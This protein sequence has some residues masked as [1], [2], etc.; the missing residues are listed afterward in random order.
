MQLALPQRTRRQNK[1]KGLES[2]IYSV[3]HLFSFDIPTYL[4]H[5]ILTSL[6]CRAPTLVCP[7]PFTVCRAKPGQTKPR[8][9]TPSH[10]KPSQKKLNWPQPQPQI[11]KASSSRDSSKVALLFSLF[12]LP[13]D[14]P[15]EPTDRL[16]Y[17]RQ[18]K[19]LKSIMDERWF[20]DH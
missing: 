1:W 9:A 12:S 7:F 17:E 6:R 5:T 2:T 15:N 4:H 13:S 20:L 10:T 8:Q 11:E 19:P 18:S 3:T 16:T 14:R